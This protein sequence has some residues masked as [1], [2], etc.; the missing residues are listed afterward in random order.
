[1]QYLPSLWFLC[2]AV[3]IGNFIDAVAGGGG[4]ITLPAYMLTGMPI[5]FAYGCN[6]FSSSVGTTMATS[7]YIRS[8]SLDM[9]A[10]LYA[11]VTAM[12]GSVIGARVALAVNE[13]VLKTIV[14][15]VLPFVAVFMI[16]YRR[17][18]STMMVTHVEGSRNVVIA[19]VIGLLV[20]FYDGIIGPGTGTF[21][22]LFFHYLMKYDMRIAAGNAKVLNLASNYAALATYIMAG[23]LYFSIAVPVAACGIF[24]SYLGSRL[25]IK[26]GA[27][28][29]RPIMILVIF[30]LIGK[31]LLDL[32]NM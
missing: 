23:T 18:E 5:H 7:Q 29:I 22:I 15:I 24:G 4:L 31:M 13:Q 8:K 20:G 10:A 2:P 28:F 3:L 9:K 6:K 12:V 21:A 25:A 17:P 32:I 19:L 1:M 30:L 26:K 16:F 27:A 14:T 11:A